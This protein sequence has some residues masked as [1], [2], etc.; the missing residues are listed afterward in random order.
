MNEI[1][2]T[3]V[4]VE[5]YEPDTGF[6]VIRV[7]EGAG[8][9]RLVGSVVDPSKGTEF[10]AEGAFMDHD[11]FG[12]CFVARRTTATGVAE[13]IGELPLDVQR[14][15]LASPDA[16]PYELDVDDD[17]AERVARITGV[18]SEDRIRSL[19]DRIMR[20]QRG[21]CGLGEREL[22]AILAAKTGSGEAQIGMVLKAM[23]EAEDLRLLGNG[24]VVPAEAYDA[25]VAFIQALPDDFERHDFDDVQWKALEETEGAVADDL[26]PHERE[27]VKVA[28]GN[29]VAVIDCKDPD[30]C[31][32]IRASLNTASMIYSGD[33]CRNQVFIGDADK[34]GEDYP[35]F[36]ALL[37][38]AS[39][40]RVH[41]P[42]E[43]ETA[44]DEAKAAIIRSRDLRFTALTQGDETTFRDG[45]EDD[46]SVWGAI[47]GA[48]E[49]ASGACE[50]YKE[51]GVTAMQVVVA[52]KAGPL[53]AESLNAIIASEMTK[54]PH[55]AGRFRIGDKIIKDGRV[56]VVDEI[57]MDVEGASPAWA[58][59][60]E[61][62]LSC[63]RKWD[64]VVLVVDDDSSVDWLTA[65][66]SL[67]MA[68]QQFV[69][70]GSR[71]A[72]Q[73]LRDAAHGGR[74]VDHALSEKVR[75]HEVRGKKGVG[76]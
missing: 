24:M 20:T 28:L 30:R 43:V 5:F 15:V 38:I 46:Y 3:V 26:T 9:F 33:F 47:V 12:P 27:A 16:N 73:R 52:T 39:V 17:T 69:A 37:D 60:I 58:L 6:G 1:V 45:Y 67:L 19:V 75:A 36:R 55:A 48:P 68:R 10:R 49:A 72:L 65:Y 35:T 21:R 31:E 50:F 4:E 2:C 29:A 53:G 59:T 63:D 40:P 11:L 61:D 51:R 42:I 76:A 74:C 34:L 25:A 64:L 8:T 18:P 66:N 62:A 56:D 57:G 22:R 7:R 70:C 14:K 23:L 71:R 13:A 32:A 41:V 54:G 44:I